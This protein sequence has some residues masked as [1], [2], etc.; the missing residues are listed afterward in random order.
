MRP[1]YEDTDDLREFETEEC[2]SRPIPK[3]WWILF[4][5]LIIWGIYYIY[6]YTPAFT[7]WSQE[8]ELQEELAKDPVIAQRIK[9]KTEPA[10]V[11]EKN[12]LA[13][14]VK[15]IAL[16]KELY[17]KNCAACHGANG[18]GGIGPS[19]QDKVWLGTEREITD[20]EIFKII[21]KGTDKGMPPY[22]AQFDKNA[23]WSMV[24]F[25]RTLQ[26]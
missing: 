13:G 11:E 8:K 26:K 22:E 21:A 2:C 23:I 7:G 4:W 5:G 10:P 20:S 16:G 25:I 17:V 18:E 15:A 19:L 3:G 9:A 12:P 14:D 1:V 24:S 6:A